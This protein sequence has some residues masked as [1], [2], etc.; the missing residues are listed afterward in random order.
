MQG[1]RA[2]G[3]SPLPLFKPGVHSECITNSSSKEMC[4]PG[5]TTDP[6]ASEI[7]SKAS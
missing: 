4:R 5:V 7:P 6:K 2:Q 1:L 3:K